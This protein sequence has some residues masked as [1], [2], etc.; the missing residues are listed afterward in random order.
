MSKQMYEKV[1]EVL[2]H[3]FEINAEDTKNAKGN[4]EI[5]RFSAK[6]FEIL[7]IQNELIDMFKED[8]IGFCEKQFLK[9][10]FPV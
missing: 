3:R 9:K 8:N 6:G 1:A 5:T 4:E 2:R 7:A 10:S